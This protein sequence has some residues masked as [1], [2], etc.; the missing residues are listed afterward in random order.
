MVYEG[1]ERYR[2]GLEVLGPYLAHV[3]LKSAL[4]S[5][6][7][8]QWTPMFAPLRDGIVDVRALLDA[9]GAVGYDDWISFEDFSTAQPQLDRTR[10]NLRYAREVVEVH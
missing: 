6:T 5:R 7:G 10:D 3:H 9:L 4:W 2:M 1:Y 8:E